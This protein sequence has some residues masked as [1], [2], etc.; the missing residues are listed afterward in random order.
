[1]KCACFLKR[2]AFPHTEVAALYTDIFQVNGSWERGVSVEGV[3][4]TAANRLSSQSRRSISRAGEEHAPDTNVP[5]D[6]HRSHSTKSYLLGGLLWWP[7]GTIRV[8]RAP[9]LP[10]RWISSTGCSAGS[11]RS[12]ALLLLTSPPPWF[13]LNRTVVKSCSM[14][15]E[16]LAYFTLTTILEY[17]LNFTY[18][19]DCHQPIVVN[20][21]PK[22]NVWSYSFDASFDASSE[23]PSAYR[24]ARPV[25]S[26]RIGSSAV[27]FTDSFSSFSV[28]TLFSKHVTIWSIA[29]T[30]SKMHWKPV[31]AFSLSKLTR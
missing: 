26:F 9:R 24:S 10:G 4:Q 30:G 28:M 1:M 27:M 7:G 2:A 22:E 18:C 15:E 25:C 8:W 6:H 3:H 23:L 5:P 12:G 21:Q 14:M 19:T 11:P 31:A 29:V 17:V 20:H 16:L 13:D